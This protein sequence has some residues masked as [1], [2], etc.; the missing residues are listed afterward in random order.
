[1][2]SDNFLEDTTVQEQ[3]STQNPNI[4]TDAPG[5]LAGT[6]VD[7]DSVKEVLDT[8]MGF[9]SQ[10]PDFIGSFFGSYKQPLI[11]IGLILASLVTV[12]LL[13]A[14]LG[15]INEVPLLS[16]V[17]ELVGISYSAWFVYRYLLKASTR[18]ELVGEIN[19]FKAQIFG[20]K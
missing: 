18:T 8:V 2:N 12:K 10:I 3:T 16:P 9:F 6:P 1:M 15:A 20:D 13:F 4:K 7:T 11:T 5:S 19:S 14:V 17:F